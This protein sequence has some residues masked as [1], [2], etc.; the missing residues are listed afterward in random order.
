MYDEML[1]GLE[2]QIMGKHSA[3]RAG[4]TG[5]EKVKGVSLTSWLNSEASPW[6]LVS[7]PFSRPTRRKRW[8]QR[9]SS[10]G[11]L[12]PALGLPPQGSPSAF[13][14]SSCHLCGVPN[15]LTPLHGTWLAGHVLLERPFYTCYVLHSCFLSNNF[16]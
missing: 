7:G 1:W 10:S 3:V 9:S 13:L 4:A 8:E 14:C 2:M 11:L 12:L 5:F 16:S 15:I 6:A